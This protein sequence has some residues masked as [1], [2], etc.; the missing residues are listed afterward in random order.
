ML[1]GLGS[2]LVLFSLMTY[3]GP[4]LVERIGA[5]MRLT[6]LADVQAALKLEF[7]S[8][9][10]HG[11]HRPGSPDASNGVGLIDE[12][13]LD[14]G[15]IIEGAGFLP[16]TP[17]AK[18]LIFRDTGGMNITWT[19]SWEDN[20]LSHTVASEYFNDEWSRT[21]DDCQNE[22]RLR[23]SLIDLRERVEYAL[24]EMAIALACRRARVAIRRT[25]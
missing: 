9:A 17:A 23:K 13:V 6:S 7:N 21:L 16:E 25:R 2:T 12:Y 19:I 15:R 5:S 18:Q 14:I 20:A 22:I 24:R 11:L 1:V 4:R 3:A 10:W 8:A